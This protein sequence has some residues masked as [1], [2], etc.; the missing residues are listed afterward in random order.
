MIALGKMPKEITAHINAII[1]K[2]LISNPV[3]K[4]K[5]KPDNKNEHAKI[6]QQIKIIGKNI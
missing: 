4:P 3:A 6:I 2:L 1:F 5:N